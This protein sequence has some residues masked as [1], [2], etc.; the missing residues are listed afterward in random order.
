VLLSQNAPVA[1]A[2]KKDG[3]SASGNG[4]ISLSANATP[5]TDAFSHAMISS[6]GKNRTKLEQVTA[7]NRDQSATKPTI[8]S[9][10]KLVELGLHKHEHIRLPEAKSIQSGDK[11]GIPLSL[12]IRKQH[13]VEASDEVVFFGRAARHS[14][15]DSKEHDS[16]TGGGVALM[17][18]AAASHDASLS[19]A[20][21][22]PPPEGGVA[23]NQGAADHH[24]R[25]SNNHKSSAT[26]GVA[27]N[28]GVACSGERNHQ[29]T[30]YVTTIP[31]ERL[32]LNRNREPTDE[33]RN[34]AGNKIKY[35]FV[36][37][38]GSGGEGHVCLY[39][40]NERPSQLCAIKL[41][42]KVEGYKTKEAD[43][44][45]VR[46][47]RRYPERYVIMDQELDLGPNSDWYA[48]RFA[49]YKGGDLASYLERTFTDKPVPEDFI[50]HFFRQCSWILEFLHEGKV[51]G[52]TVSS[53]IPITHGDLKPANFLVEDVSSGKSYPNIKLADFGCYAQDLSKKSRGD[54]GT[55]D[56]IPPEWEIMYGPT[57]DMFAMGVMVHQMAW[58][59]YPW[60]PNI[61][62]S[63]QWNSEDVHQRYMKIRKLAIRPLMEKKYSHLLNEHMYWALT[64][65]TQRATAG[66]FSASLREIFLRGLEMAPN[67]GS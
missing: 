47:L 63:P 4:G 29:P 7:D 48:L 20:Q 31:D 9:A 21:K 10:G 61:K 28:G 13:N 18:N 30:K 40:H 57:H 14:A 41:I 59:E 49:Y 43:S 17:K 42:K 35:S 64:H 19:E 32:K 36:T 22:S 44:E 6:S 37:E 26:G 24:A 52:K 33:T 60:H 16:A 38:L 3:A 5:P 23:L 39:R 66:Q 25:I 58:N 51:D 50:W 46:L 53:H 1:T 12:S 56:Y 8:P 45:L 54:V 67:G 2:S 11:G 27:L 34:Q 55:R 62:L 65:Y 15:S